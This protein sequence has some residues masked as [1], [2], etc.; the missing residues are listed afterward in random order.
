M[1]IESTNIKSEWNNETT[2]LPSQ[3][4]PSIK[5]IEPITTIDN[6]LPSDETCNKKK[7]TKYISTINKQKI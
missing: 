4:I 1:Q 7:Y 3:S 2:Q 5:P 6:T